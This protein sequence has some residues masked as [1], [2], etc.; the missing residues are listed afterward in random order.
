MDID[1]SDVR[2]ELVVRPLLADELER[3][4]EVDSE[5]FGDDAWPRYWFEE[6]IADP[7]VTIFVAELTDAGRLV[8]FCILHVMGSDCDVA[9]IAVGRG[10]RR[11]GVGRKM[12][13]TLLDAARA[14][15]LS[16]VRLRVRPDNL[17]A[18]KLYE[19]FGFR[20][21]G[22]DRGYYESGADAENMILEL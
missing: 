11:A 14:L 8:G 22:I 6:L 13:G 10:T 21:T 19:S 15:N 12:L 2:Y 3:V 9:N 7:D 4:I 18:K 5:A 17:G 1:L 20:L 16:S